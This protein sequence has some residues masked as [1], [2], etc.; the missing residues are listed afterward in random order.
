MKSSV[1]VTAA[2]F[3]SF[4]STA[5]ANNMSALAGQGR[6]V[7]LN[8]STCKLETFYAYDSTEGTGIY[9]YPTSTELLSASIIVSKDATKY[10][11]KPVEKEGR[12]AL[13][14]SF[15]EKKNLRQHILAYTNGSFLAIAAYDNVQP[16]APGSTN[17]E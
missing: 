12:L 11:V 6:E 15:V 13:K 5:S 17:Q 9:C 1:F 10:E 4:L 14:I 3:I 2:L 7:P 8:E 16:V